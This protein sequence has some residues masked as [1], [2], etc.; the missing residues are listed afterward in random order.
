MF[1]SCSRIMKV[2]HMFG[3]CVTPLVSEARWES[4]YAWY[5]NREGN[6]SGFW[7]DTLEAT[8]CLQPSL[9]HS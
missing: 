6:R 3:L 4:T 9:S 1:L 5:L 2:G 7:G 8:V